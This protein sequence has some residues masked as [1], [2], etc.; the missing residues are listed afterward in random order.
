MKSIR[1]SILEGEFPAFVKHFMERLYPDK[2]YEQWTVDALNSVGIHL[3][4]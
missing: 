3:T 4:L 1:T 2:Q